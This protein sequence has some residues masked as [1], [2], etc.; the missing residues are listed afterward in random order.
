M[1]SRVI[2]KAGICSR[3]TLNLRSTTACKSTLSTNRRPI[4]ATV[5]SLSPKSQATY[6]ADRKKVR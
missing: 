2:K 6:R 3:T 5:L 1:T 4:H